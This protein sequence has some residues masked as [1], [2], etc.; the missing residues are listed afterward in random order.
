MQ[1]SY[2]V[3]DDFGGPLRGFNSKR[4]ALWFIE[5]KPGLTIQATG[6]KLPKKPPDPDPYTLAFSQCGSAPF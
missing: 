4:E 2:I 6:Y 5:G 1:Y 3:L